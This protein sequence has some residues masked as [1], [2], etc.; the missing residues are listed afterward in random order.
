MGWQKVVGVLLR[1]QAERRANPTEKGVVLVLGCNEHQRH[2]LDK[3][4]TRQLTEHPLPPTP[5]GDNQGPATTTGENL[6]QNSKENPAGPSDEAQEEGGS[7]EILSQGSDDFKSPRGAAVPAG[8]P[9]RPPAVQEVLGPRGLTPGPPADISADTP[10]VQRS[11]LYRN[12]AA[13]FVTT[14]I[15]VVDMLSARLLPSQVRTSVKSICECC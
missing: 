2:M 12:E 6:Q 5:S 1:L 13:V 8:A 14:R 4:V 10:A 15:L 7:I 11:E 9:V 3:E